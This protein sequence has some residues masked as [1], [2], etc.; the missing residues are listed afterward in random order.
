MI[1]TRILGCIVVL[2]LFTVAEVQAQGYLDGLMNRATESAKRKAQDR[3]NQNIDQSI[4]KAIRKTEDTVKCVATDQ[5]CLRRAKEEGKQVEMVDKPATHDTMK[6]LITDSGCMK[7]AKAQHKKVE[8]VEEDQLDTLRCST[9][10]TDCLARAKTKGKKVEIIDQIEP[11]YSTES[12]IVERILPPAND[13]TRLSRSIAVGG[14][15]P[16]SIRVKSGFACDHRGYAPT[17]LRPRD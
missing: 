15:L 13:G 7:Q 14:D 12:A 6:C 1:M 16:V 4:D 11:Y 17:A 5:E 3:V 8:I 9:T 10:D 2:M